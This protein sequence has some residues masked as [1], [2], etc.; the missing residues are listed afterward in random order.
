MINGL[1]ICQNDLLK[2][3][4]NKIDFVN[5]YLDNIRNDNKRTLSI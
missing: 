1:L 5:Q 2:K 4:Q 3:L